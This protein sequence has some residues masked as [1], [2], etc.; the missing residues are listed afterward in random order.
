MGRLMIF[1]GQLYRVSL[2]DLSVDE[3]GDVFLSPQ[4]AFAAELSFEISDL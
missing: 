1:A 4:I 2:D 3:V